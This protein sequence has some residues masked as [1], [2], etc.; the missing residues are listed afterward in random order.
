M[1]PRSPPTTRLSPERYLQ[2][3]SLTNTSSNEA[4]K[5]ALSR[6][7]YIGP[8]SLAERVSSGPGLALATGPAPQAGTAM[9]LGLGL[10]SQN[11]VFA[12]MISEVPSGCKVP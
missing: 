10:S 5:A 3:G 11:E 9:H 7:L 4:S 6:L 12:Q 8:M 2:P 1:R